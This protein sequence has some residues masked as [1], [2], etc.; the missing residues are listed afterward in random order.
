MSIKD[1]PQLVQNKTDAP[2]P[3]KVTKKA[4]QHLGLYFLPGA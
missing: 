4:S 3:S 2:I 1:Q